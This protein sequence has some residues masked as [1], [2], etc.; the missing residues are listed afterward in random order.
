MNYKELLLKDVTLL[1]PEVYKATL[2]NDKVKYRASFIFDKG[3]DTDIHVRKEIESF[4][5]SEFPKDNA[6]LKK[7]LGSQA[8]RDK[9]CYKDG[10]DE[11]KEKGFQG[12]M[13][14]KASISEFSI[15]GKANNPPKILDMDAVTAI[16]EHTGID[17]VTKLPINDKIYSGA[18][19][20]AI[21]ALFAIQ[22]ANKQGVFALLKKIQF[23]GHGEPILAADE[24]MGFEPVEIKVIETDNDLI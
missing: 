15:S 19:V 17:D 8:H 18:K 7:N 20:N 11:D 4:I 10:Y 12:K 21:V 6:R 5:D 9:C 1:W 14:F 3:S 16:P 24:G 22:E 2:Y 13:L 23:I